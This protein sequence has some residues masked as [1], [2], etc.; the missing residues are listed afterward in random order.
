ML[1]KIVKKD[2]VRRSKRRSTDIWDYLVD[3]VVT[4]VESRSASALTSSALFTSF[5]S[6]GRR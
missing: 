4:I 2:A 3:N 1:S 6:V 5:G